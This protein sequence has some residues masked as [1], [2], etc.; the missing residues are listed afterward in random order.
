MVAT[1][2][3]S[4]QRASTA[5]NNADTNN[6]KPLVTFQASRTGPKC[7]YGNESVTF[8]LYPG[9]CVSLSGASGAGKTTLSGFLAGLSSRS[10]L[11]KLDIVVEQCSWDES[12]EPGERVGVLFQQTTLINA[13]TVAG[14]VCVALEA[15][16]TRR[17]EKG[18]QSAEDRDRTIK[19]LLDMVGLDYARDGPKR[20]TEL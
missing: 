1:R 6:D 17:K 13:L 7:P 16:A 19:Q 18:A 2:S 5:G 4:R 20:P 8:A 15:C 9:A 11:R 12:L 3:S 14:N 10:D